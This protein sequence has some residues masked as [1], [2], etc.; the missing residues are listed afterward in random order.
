[1]PSENSEELLQLS[2]L[3]VQRFQTRLVTR[4]QAAFDYRLSWLRQFDK[5]PWNPGLSNL[6]SVRPKMHNKEKRKKHVDRKKRRKERKTER[7][8]Q[9]K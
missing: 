2:Q 3:L 5:A 8:K 9:L 4:W 7:E 6:N 1:M